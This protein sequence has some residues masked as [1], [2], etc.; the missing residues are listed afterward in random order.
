MRKTF[1]FLIVLVLLASR[2]CAY[3]SNFNEELE[4]WTFDGLSAELVSGSLRLREV[5]KLDYGWGTCAADFKAAKYLQIKVSAS[6]VAEHQLSM[7]NAADN[8]EFAGQLLEGWNTFA[9]PKEQPFKLALRLNGYY[10]KEPG[11]WID[12]KKIRAV[13]IPEDGLVF[14][15]ESAEIGLSDTFGLKYYSRP[16]LGELSVTVF[17]ADEMSL[18]SFGKPIILKDHGEDGDEQAGDGVYS[19]LCQPDQNANR[20]LGPGNQAIKGSKL[21]FAVNLPN[22]TCSYGSPSFDFRIDSSKPLPRG[23]GLTPTAAKFRKQWEMLLQGKT[24]LA[25]G[26]KVEFSIEPDFRLTKKG[27]NDAFDLTDGILS[28]RRDDILRFDSKAVGWRSSGDLSEGIDFRIDLGKVEAVEKV[29]IRINCGDRV[30]NIQ[31]SPKSLAVLV[32]KDGEYFYP[33]STPMLK[34][35]PGEKEQSDFESQFYLEENDEVIFCFPFA[36]NVQAYARHILLRIVPDGGNLYT[37]E[38][39]IL[40]AENPNPGFDKAYAKEGE[41]LHSDGIL[42]S[43]AQSGKFYV[44]DNIPAPNYFKHRDLRKTTDKAKCKQVIELPLGIKCLNKEMESEQ[45]EREGIAMTRYSRDMPDKPQRYAHFL[46]HQPLFL[47]AD[48]SAPKNGKV[49]FYVSI[50]GAPSIVGQS[51]LEI[52]T[53]PECKEQF[54]G[55]TVLSRMGIGEGAWPGYYDNLRKLGFSGAQFYP[56]MY[57][58]QGKEELPASFCDNIAKAKM[59]GYKLV[60]GFN[61]LAEMYHK[62]NYPG[63]KLPDEVFCQYDDNDTSKNPCPS[64]RGKYYQ[65]EMAKVYRSVLEFKPQ[66]IQWDIEHWGGAIRKIQHCAR[67]RQRQQE[68]GKEWEQFLDELSLELEQ[69]LWNTVS[70]AAQQAGA[71]LPLIYNYNRQ[72][73]PGGAKYHGF[74]TW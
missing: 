14:S 23:K 28:S 32:S 67:C 30:D 4:F 53:L 46:E 27:D 19:A 42:I 68:S 41:K 62:G 60:L 33:A 69:E 56:Y 70:Q 18:V 34:L 59:E 35:Q 20:L 49:F 57:L 40:K 31:R 8:Y 55:I 71:P 50:D 61:G 25:S 37:D 58:R 48:Q 11:G 38:L 52:I 29:L 5:S 15:S 3:E 47:Q 54:K 22:E 36:L 1:S 63:G 74:E 13:Q 24:N 10:G 65:S 51:E 12:V 73:R 43:P 21:V 7:A 72:A 44:A 26:K 16:G 45:I 2:L 64:Y 6:E 39:A 66:Y 17:H 9:L